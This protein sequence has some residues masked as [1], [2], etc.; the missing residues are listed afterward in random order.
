MQSLK[1]KELDRTYVELFAMFSSPGWKW[2]EAEARK[3]RDR[4]DTVRGMDDLRMLGM[5][6]GQLL[7]LDWLIGYPQAAEYAYTEILRSEGQ[8]VDEPAT[9][10]K[11]EILL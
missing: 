6:Q 9:P 1:D 5:Q 7:N 2:F 4:L 10:G 11:A 3:L 8:D